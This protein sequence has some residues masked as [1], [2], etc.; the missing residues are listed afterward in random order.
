MNTTTKKPNHLGLYAAA[1]LIGFAMITE[2]KVWGDSTLPADPDV[3]AEIQAQGIQAMN[4][5]ASTNNSE[6]FWQTR[7]QNT[8]NEHFA[9][10]RAGQ[11]Q[12]ASIDHCQ[13][14]TPNITQ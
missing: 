8:L 6:C 11:T 10:Y 5:I 2:S 3:A 9:A 12:L 1:L 13:C 7:L 4:E 14:G